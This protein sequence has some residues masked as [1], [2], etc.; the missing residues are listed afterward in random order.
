MGKLDMVL[1]HA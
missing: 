1:F